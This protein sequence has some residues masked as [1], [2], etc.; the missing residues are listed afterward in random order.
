[1]NMSRRR[2]ISLFDSKP[3][4]ALA[5]AVLLAGCSGGVGTPGTPPPAT[6]TVGGAVTGL[7]G[8]GLILHNNGGDSV[9]VSSAGSFVFPTTIASGGACSV[10]VSVQ[11]TGPSQTCTVTNGSGAIG[12]SNDQRVWPRTEI[13]H[14]EQESEDQQLLREWRRPV[15]LSR[16]VTRSDYFAGQFCTPKNH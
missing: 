6:Y 16:A 11:P 15:G 9:A 12:L 8:S 7:A 13:L 14:A 5:I 2:Q 1:M 4:A 10:T 3:L